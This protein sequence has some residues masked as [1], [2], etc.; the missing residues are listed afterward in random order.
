MSSEQS[1]LRTTL[2]GS[3]LDVASRNR[4]RG[5]GAIRL[6]EAGA[7]YLPGGDALP[8]EPYHVGALLAGP[9]RPATWREQAPREAD[10]F[11]AKGV[12]AGLLDGLGVDWRVEPAAEPEPFL[13]PGRAARIVLDGDAD[14]MGR[15][16]P[17]AGRGRVGLGTS[18]SPAFEL[19]LD[20]SRSGTSSPATAT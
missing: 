15:R 17:S 1:Q 2:L 14:R 12:L 11:A 4:A 8:G 13:H 16:D 20:R 10:F 7:V 19:D 18:R 9:V 6:F 3:L 5:G